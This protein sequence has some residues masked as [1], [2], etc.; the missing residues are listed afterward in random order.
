MSDI[1]FKTSN[2]VTTEL[3]RINQL[4]A[5]VATKFPQLDDTTLNS[6]YDILK[7]TK[8]DTFPRIRYFGIGINGYANI[9]AKN[10]IAQPY[11]P[12]SSNMDLYTPIPFRCTKVP[13]SQQEA[14][15]YRLV[16]PMTINGE[17]YYCYWLKL[18]EFESEYPKITMIT[19]N[20]ETSYSLDT[21]NLTPTP[22]NL[23]GTDVANAN[24]STTEVSITAIRKVTGAE[25]VEVIN[26]M[27]GGDLRKAR[28]SEFGL[29]SGI[30]KTNSIEGIE[31]TYPEAAYVQLASHMCCIGHDLSAIGSSI[32]ERV[33]ISNGSLAVL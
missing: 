22:T 28:I 33:V 19:G 14:A 27:F 29:Y 10:N 17:T 1:A 2:V 5:A 30:E 24:G 7:G 25:V 31:Y 15:Q 16:Q 18:L 20:R 9:S 8:L 32:T 4:A 13:L 26:A 11:Q 12:K 3:G 21:S 6:K 23:V